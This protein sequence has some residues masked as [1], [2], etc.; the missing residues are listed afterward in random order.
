MHGS[1]IQ[2]DSFIMGHRDF[3]VNLTLTFVI[4]FAQK[5]ICQPNVKHGGGDFN[6]E[7]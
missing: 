3:N 1:N 4:S 5:N 6:F 7:V 2:S